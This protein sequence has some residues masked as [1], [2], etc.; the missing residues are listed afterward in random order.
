MDYAIVRKVIRDCFKVDRIHY[1]QAPVLTVAHD[2]DRSLLHNGKYYSPLIDTMEDDLAAKGLRCLSVARIVSTIKGD[3]AYGRVVSPEGGFARALVQKRLLGAL[4]R[5]AYPY[6][7]MEEAVWGNLLDKTKAKKVFG[8]QPSRELC[9]ACHKRGVWVA[10]VQHGVIA[11]THPWYGAAFRAADP[12]EYLP[13]AFLLWDKGSEEVIANWARTKSISFH[14]IGN[15]WL[16][17]FARPLNNDR[18]VAELSRNFEHNAAKDNTKKT[19]LVSLSW[20]VDNIPNGFIISGLERVIRETNRVYRWLIRLHP[21]QIRGFAIDEG[22][23]FVKYFNNNLRGC[24]EWE[25]TTRAPLPV[26][27]KNIDL[28]ISWQ[29]SVSIE[30]AQMGVRSAL[31]DPRLRS[32]AQIGDYYGYYRRAG[33]IDLVEETG[34]AIR[35]WIEAKLQYK[36]APESFDAYDV[37]YRRLIDLLAE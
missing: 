15:R 7:R 22:P 2:N 23:R 37:A 29:S 30:A 13:S 21:N 16:A 31:L 27:L 35:R 36:A 28:H 12:L 1:E 32:P 3:L 5:K 14:V 8:I 25:Q 6:S 10:D 9:V 11:D 34:P 4:R 20:G 17:R 19:I 33:M 24:A 18:L 26:I